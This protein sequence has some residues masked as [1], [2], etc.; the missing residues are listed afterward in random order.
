MKQQQI[1]PAEQQKREN[2]ASNSESLL[3]R[4]NFE[5][6]TILFLFQSGILLSEIPVGLGLAQN[7]Y[8]YMDKLQNSCNLTAEDIAED[9]RS[10]NDKKNKPE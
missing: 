7:I 2:F 5:I 9:W 1:A 10:E 4:L 6:S 3:L 8:I